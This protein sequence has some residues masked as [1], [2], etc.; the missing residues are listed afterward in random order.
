[1]LFLIQMQAI[2]QLQGALEI[3]IESD[4]NPREKLAAAVKCHVRTVTQRHVAG[5]LRQQELILPKKWRNEIV[6]QRD[7]YDGTFLKI[8]E[9]GIEKG[10]FQAL[11]WKTSK[12]AALGALNW[13]VRW[14][15]PKGKLSVDEI[16]EAMADFILQGFGVRQNK[17]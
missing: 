4:K 12:M 16:G 1:M 15:S 10:V 11:D 14:Y 8:I 2:E 7:H 5:A 17:K 3:V 9:E 6:A 13:I